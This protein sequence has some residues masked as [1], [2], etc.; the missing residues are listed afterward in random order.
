M[1]VEDR[2]VSQAS[3][4]VCVCRRVPSK[5]RESKASRVCV[6][7]FVICKSGETS[8]LFRFCVANGEWAEPTRLSNGPENKEWP[9]GLCVAGSHTY[10]IH[11]HIMHIT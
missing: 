11:T 9:Q 6:C 8:P 7:V 4:C 1:K 2:F 3:K 5:P 10:D